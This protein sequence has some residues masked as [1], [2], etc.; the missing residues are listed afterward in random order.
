MIQKKQVIGA[1]A[2]F[3][4]TALVVGFFALAADFGGKEN[5]L[6][7]L[8]YL[9]SLYPQIE[10]T[11]ENTVREKVDVQI[12]GIEE[13]IR[14]AVERIN[15]MSPGGSSPDLSG[16]LNDEDFINRVAA[17]VAAQIGASAGGGLDATS[18]RVVVDTGK[19]LHL[20]LGS[21]VMLRL[22]TGTVVASNAPGLIDTTT[23]QPLDNGGV[24]T[25]NHMYTVTMEAGR[26]IKC[27]S[28]MTVFI[29]GPY[30]IS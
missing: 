24:L 19:T 29:W 27:S 12:Q 9:T 15:E 7:T 18:Q 21:S 22:G 10:T 3:I 11:I 17:E 30:T 25:A 6:V 20:P 13:Q 28:T 14:Q 5:P 16:M 23:A 1:A 2:F 4:L 8:D 26:D